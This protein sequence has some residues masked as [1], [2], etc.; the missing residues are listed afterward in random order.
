MKPRHVAISTAVVAIAVGVVLVVSGMPPGLVLLFSSVVAVGGALA[1]AIV[2]PEEPVLPERP[3]S[4]RGGA[5]RE[6]G[7]V[8]WSLRSSRGRVSPGASARLSAVAARRLARL[9][10]DLDDP[11]DR[12][13][14]EAALGA[15]AYRVVSEPD[16]RSFSTMR[17][18]IRAV[19]QLND[20]SATR[21]PAAVAPPATAPRS[22]G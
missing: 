15:R 14:A 11:A 1:T 17:A 7:S 22:P 3:T 5:R 16:P 4:M 2:D 19:D 13:R 6:V 12:P 21:P 9:G 8:A 10:I 20:P 18:A